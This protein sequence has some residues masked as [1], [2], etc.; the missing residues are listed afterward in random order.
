M[1]TL[2]NLLFVCS[3]LI[4][5]T[6]CSAG[7][8]VETIPAD[9]SATVIPVAEE[10]QPQ[11]N[12]EP[13]VNLMV[14]WNNWNVYPGQIFGTVTDTGKDMVQVYKDNDP[15]GVIIVQSEDPELL[16]AEM[17][18][19]GQIVLQQLKPFEGKAVG[20][21]VTYR[22]NNYTFY[23]Y[24]DSWTG[25]KYSAEEGPVNLTIR[26]GESNIMAGQIFGNISG[27]GRDAV[28]VYHEQDPVSFITVTSEDP[29]VLHAEAVGV[30]QILL[31]KL[32]PF[33]GMALGFT[34][35]YRGHDYTFYCNDDSWDPSNPS[36]YR[37]A[38]DNQ[39]T[40]YPV[41]EEA[42]FMLRQY[43][44]TELQAFVDD[45]L[46]F[47]ESCE[48]L[49]T[50]ADAIQYLYLRGYHFKPD[51]G[52]TKASI[53]YG[54]NSG[55]CVGS[56][57]LFNAILEGDYDAQGYVYIFYS[58]TEHVFNYYVLDGVYYYCDFVRV[59]GSNGANPKT[60]PVCHI[61]TDP[62]T[63]YD[64]WMKIEPHDM[65]D[66]ESDFYLAAMYTTDYC[67]T[68]TMPKTRLKDTKTG[69]YAHIPLQAAE[70]ESQQILFI[71]D[72]YT[73]KF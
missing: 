25:E 17:G 53:R 33:G 18:G 15:V 51:D 31:K 71:R 69:T 61:T 12:K 41:A 19:M 35:N 8:T 16:R 32:K 68:P 56:S 44:D 4:A 3:L 30:G 46:S 43:T 37:E 38:V 62:I 24:D 52:G 65:N 49:S 70:K 40:T 10:S 45:D 11:E 58:R 28:T 27:S 26:W 36:F 64:A 21:I 9:T 59:F 72:G 34:V 57:A 73:F 63:I 22:G 54:L 42:E 47:E 55:A 7:K 39:Q 14:R 29:E 67:G 20:F 6:G 1:K 66:S 60:S 2:L 23:C 13:L 50:V 5:M 48:K